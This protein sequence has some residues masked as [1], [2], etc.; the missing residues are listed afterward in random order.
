MGLI[1]RSPCC[2]TYFQIIK[3]SAIFYYYRQIFRSEDEH[4]LASCCAVGI[5]VELIFSRH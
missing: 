2:F 1:S 5:F 3:M 4:F